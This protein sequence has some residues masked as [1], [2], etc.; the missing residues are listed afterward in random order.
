MDGDDT[1]LVVYSKRFLAPDRHR[2]P[3]DPDLDVVTVEFVKLHP[4]YI[5]PNNSM[6]FISDDDGSGYNGCHCEDLPLVIAPTGR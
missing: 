1:Q 6:E 5:A 4:Q 3:R 2:L